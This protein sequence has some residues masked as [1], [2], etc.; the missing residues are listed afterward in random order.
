[1]VNIWRAYFDLISISNDK[2]NNYLSAD[3]S[4]PCDP[5]NIEE[6][7]RRSLGTDYDLIIRN[8]LEQERLALQKQRMLEAEQ[9]QMILQK[10]QQQEAAAAAALLAVK[11]QQQQQ[12]MIKHHKK[13]QIHQH[14]AMLI[15]KQNQSANLITTTPPSTPSPPVHVQQSSPISLQAPQNIATIP[16]QQK[17]QVIMGEEHDNDEMMS[18]DD[19][20]AKA[21]GEDT[22]KQFSSSDRKWWLKF[23]EHLIG[24]CKTLSAAQ[25]TLFSVVSNTKMLNF[26]FFLMMK[27]ISSFLLLCRAFGALEMRKKAYYN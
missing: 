15:A 27:T 16:Q 2:S 26:F 10:Q 1:M 21:L 14:Q 4:T 8:N 17:Q 9:Q 6:H 22:W 7:F 23:A 19:H 13:H 3:P 11:Q 24:N 20:F 25:Q 18:V 5:M 12:G